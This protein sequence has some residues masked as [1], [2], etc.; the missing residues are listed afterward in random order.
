ADVAHLSW[1]DDLHQQLRQHHT[2]RTWSAGRGERLDR[3]R[4]AKTTWDP[5]D[6]FRHCHHIAPASARV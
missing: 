1:T 6:A 2:E 4:Q 5:D 3:L